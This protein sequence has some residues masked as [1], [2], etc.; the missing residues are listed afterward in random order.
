VLDCDVAGVLGV[1]PGIVGTIQ[2]AEAL[3]LLLGVGE[4]L[5]GRMLN[6]DALGARFDE[7]AI[8]RDPACETCGSAA[9]RSRH[10]AVAPASA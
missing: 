3:K 8:P 10:A 2:A 1:L 5:I 4:P 7:I 6:Y 9:A